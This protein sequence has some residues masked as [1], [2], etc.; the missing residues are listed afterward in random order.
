M[1]IHRCVD[2]VLHVAGPPRSIHARRINE[3]NRKLIQVCQRARDRFPRNKGHSDFGFRLLRIQH[4]LLE[5]ETLE[6]RC[7][8]GKISSWGVAAGTAPRTVEVLLAGLSVPGL[9][10][11][12][13]HPLAS[14]IS[15]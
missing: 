7:D 1:G 14:T 4:L 5:F 3:S 15:M 8:P 12:D 11:G 10:I 2:F 13:I 9:A 6:A